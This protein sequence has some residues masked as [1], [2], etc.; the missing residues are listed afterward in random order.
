MELRELTAEDLPEV[1]Q[2]RTSVTENAVTMDELRDRYG[3]TLESVGEALKGDIQGW[4]YCE[5]VAIA[6]FIMVNRQTAEILVLAV[7]PSYENRGIG[8]TLLQHAE[9]WLIDQGH[10][11]LWLKTAAEPAFRAYGFYQHL[12]WQ[13]SGQITDR[14]EL[15]TREISE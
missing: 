15:F 13:A 7:L 6:G 4:V 8:R 12:G 5:S 3:V 10:R 14:E 11:K 9:Q 1:F 2:V